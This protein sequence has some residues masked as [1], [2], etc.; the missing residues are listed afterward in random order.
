[1]FVPC[2]ASSLLCFPSPGDYNVPLALLDVH[3]SHPR[4][5]L[6][7]FIN[8]SCLVVP[9]SF[10]YGPLIPTTTFLLQTFFIRGSNFREGWVGAIWFCA[11][12]ALVRLQVGQV[13][14]WLVG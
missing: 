9:I 1:M 2:V 4:S 7:P 3:A 11:L 5:L 12:P 13:F 10:A 8:Y 6:L 14:G